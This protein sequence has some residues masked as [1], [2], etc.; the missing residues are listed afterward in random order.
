MILTLEE[1][2]LSGITSN[3]RWIKVVATDTIRK[4]GEN[5]NSKKIRL[6][7]DKS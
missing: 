2:D 6:K 3:D 4:K 7:Q 5:T 1:G